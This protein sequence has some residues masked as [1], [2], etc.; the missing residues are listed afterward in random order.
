MRAMLSMRTGLPA[1][2]ATVSLPIVS[3]SR[4]WLS[5][6]RIFTGYCSMPSRYVEISSSPDTMSRSVVPTVDMRTPRS[7]A[8]PRSTATRISG[9][10]LLM[11]VF[12]SARLANCCPFASNCIA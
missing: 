4:R 9:L 3:M 10:L 11:L 7:A 5:S 1:E 8:R 6:T 12:G 2:D